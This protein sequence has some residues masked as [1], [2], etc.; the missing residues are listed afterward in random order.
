ML[1]DGWL[2]LAAFPLVAVVGW[3][4]GAVSRVGAVVGDGV[5]PEV[6]DGVG[7]SVGPAKA[8][9]ASPNATTNTIRCKNNFLSRFITVNSPVAMQRVGVIRSIIS[10][11]PAP[12]RAIGAW[13]HLK[14]QSL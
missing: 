8:G 10:S 1:P 2:P 7:S 9:V 12:S 6:G 4:V 14:G 3:R 13:G 11:Q 5:T